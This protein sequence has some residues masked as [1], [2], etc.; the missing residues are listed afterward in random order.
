[1]PPDTL[2]SPILYR[3][4]YLLTPPSELPPLP[5]SLHK[6]P[7][8]HNVME[9]SSRNPSY[10]PIHLYTILQVVITVV[11]FIVTLTR[12]APVFPVLIIALVP[13]RLLVMKK[14]WPREVLRFV[15][16][17]ACREGTPEDDEDAAKLDGLPTQET[18]SGDENVTPGRV[19]R[20]NTNGDDNGSSYVGERST[21]N[22]DSRADLGDQTIRHAAHDVNHEW[23]EL[24]EREV[25]D[26][27]LG[28]DR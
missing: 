13:F 11:I 7:E 14:W 27:E 9:P 15:D 18:S 1:M 3:F 26:E 22:A 28:R 21:S 12:A 5:Q 24:E 16:A 2:Y 6:D 25:P 8:A 23:V 4:F 20:H 17:W 19:F 10:F